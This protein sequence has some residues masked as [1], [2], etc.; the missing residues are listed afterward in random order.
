[1]ES[2]YI[3]DLD[4]TLIEG[5]SF[6]LFVKFALRRFPAA[7]PGIAFTVLL[8]KLRLISHREAKRRIMKMASRHFTGKPLDEFLS[9]IERRVRPFFRDILASHPAVLILAS[10]APEEYA[11]PLAKRL[12]FDAAVATPAG[13]L[14]ECR[15]ER[16]VSRLRDLGVSFDGDTRVFTDHTDDLPLLRANAHGKNYLVAPCEKLPAEARR[17]GLNFEIIPG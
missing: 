16:K 6:T 14:E 4:G 5:N 2:H 13:S 8:R 17:L 1:M 11:L 10:A 15:G 9:I 12:G 3:I 7:T